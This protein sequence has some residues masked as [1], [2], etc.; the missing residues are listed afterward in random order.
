VIKIALWKARYCFIRL[1]RAIADP[2]SSSSDFYSQV[3]TAT[4]YS[5][6]AGT[7]VVQLELVAKS[8]TLKEPE[9]D[10]DTVL[11][12]GATS[13]NQNA[14]LDE[15]QSDNAEFTATLIMNP[16]TSN[17]FNL[18]MYRFQVH[19]TVATGY[20]TRFNY[21][22]AAPTTGVSAA[23]QFTDGTNKVNFLLNNAVVTTLGGFKVEADGST[24][25]EIKIECSPDDCWKEDNFVK[26]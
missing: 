5:G 16:E 24:E 23:I 15:K 8:A 20:D 6:S 21:A 17:K 22:A 3:S 10:T 14:E 7:T 11:L 9:R 12:L 19:G 25:Q 18:D 1:G 2:G 13:G 4:G 26:P